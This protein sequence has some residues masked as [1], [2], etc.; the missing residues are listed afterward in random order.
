MATKKQ[1][2]VKQPIEQET[3]TDD[4]P[5]IFIKKNVCLNG[6]DYDRYYFG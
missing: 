6:Q 5:M 3:T 1:T 4:N 2:T